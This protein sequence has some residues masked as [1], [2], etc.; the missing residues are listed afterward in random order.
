DAE[1]RI[2]LHNVESVPIRSLTGRLTAKIVPKAG[3]EGVKPVLRRKNCPIARSAS[4]LPGRRHRSDPGPTPALK[5]MNSVRQWTGEKCVLFC[6]RRQP[7][8]PTV[9]ESLA[10]RLYYRRNER[11]SEDNGTT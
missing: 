2:C 9:D 10:G 4:R 11:R 1:V 6:C 3:K 7:A 5:S 8:Q